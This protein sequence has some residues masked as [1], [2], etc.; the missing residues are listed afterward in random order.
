MSVAIV[1]AG[2]SGLLTAIELRLLN[3]DID[4]AIFDNVTSS[5]SAIAGQR[6]RARFSGGSTLGELF[7]WYGDRGLL[8]QEVVDF[9][10]LGRK[11]LMF[12]QS[13]YPPTLNIELER[14]P[15]RDNP[16][17]FGPQL[18]DVTASGRGKG[19]SVLRWLR[20]LINPLGIRLIQSRVRDVVFCEKSVAAIIIENRLGLSKIIADNYV[21]ACGSPAGSM[22]YSTNVGNW[23]SLLPFLHI[24]GVPIADADIF[25]L[26]MAACCTKDG[27][28]KPGCHET[29]VLA[30]FTAWLRKSDSDEFVVDDD[31]TNLL[32][33]HQAH[34]RMQEICRKIISAGGLVMYKH[35][36]QSIL[37]RVSHHYSHLRLKTA[38]GVTVSEFNNA[39]VTGDMAGVGHW[40]GRH[41]RLP[42]TALLGCLVSASL[43]ANKLAR[44]VGVNKIIMASVEQVSPAYVLRGEMKAKMRAINSDGLFCYV[45]GVIAGVEQWVSELTR[46]SAH[47][48]PWIN[49][50]LSTANACLNSLLRS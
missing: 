11:Q 1:G 30:G 16:L 38:D 25:M 37:S 39:Y 27:A 47:N 34:E 26:H 23:D 8:R 6:Y 42:G 40:L 44:R 28:P 32:A 4:V 19:G 15:S 14:L 46:L 22:F 7:Q 2:V 9:Y 20:Q 12:W 3:P 41:A 35:N 31:I 5:N 49:L 48:D 29:D 33:T 17:W 10:M 43:V 50:S 21:F 18:G 45:S 13:L 24:A 36:E